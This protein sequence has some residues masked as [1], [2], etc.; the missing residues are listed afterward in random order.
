MKLNVAYYNDP[1]LREKSQRVEYIDDNLRQF[2]DDMIE[3]MLAHNGI[4]LAAPQVHHPIALFITRVPTRRLNGEWSPGRP[5]VF[6][7]PEIISFSEEMQTFSEGCLSIPNLYMNVTRPKEIKIKATDLDGNSFEETFS[8]F[9]ATNFMHENDHLKGV[10]IVDYFS[11]EERK[12][13]E[14]LFKPTS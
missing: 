11:I 6:I 5:R 1:I 3:T 10:L 12:S 4:G 8:G 2:V 14:Q 13:L 9:E 7:N